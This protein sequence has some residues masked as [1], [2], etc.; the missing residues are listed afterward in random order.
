MA[1]LMVGIT[2]IICIGPIYPRP[3]QLYLQSFLT[4]TVIPSQK[5]CNLCVRMTLTKGSKEL[6]AWFFLLYFSEKISMKYPFCINQNI[7]TNLLHNVAHINESDISI[8]VLN[9]YCVWSLWYVSYYVLKNWILMIPLRIS[10]Y[11]KPTATRKVDVIFQ[12][13]Y[14]L[15]HGNPVITF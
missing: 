1:I 15:L 14:Y 11:F 9:Q 6:R 10:M 7:C 5:C 3:W 12:L 2:T 4:T 13:Y 8:N